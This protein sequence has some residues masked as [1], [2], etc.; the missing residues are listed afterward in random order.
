MAENKMAAMDLIKNNKK[1]HFESTFLLFST[2]NG[3]KSQNN[4]SLADQVTDSNISTKK[5]VIYALICIIS[6]WP[7]SHFEPNEYKAQLNSWPFHYT[8][9]WSW[10]KYRK[11]SPLSP[12]ILDNTF[13]TAKAEWISYFFTKHDG[14]HSYSWIQ[15]VTF[16]CI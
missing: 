13:H 5:T 8:V 12:L 14:H 15:K 4:N 11:A 2:L 3:F 6:R 1:S 10:K 9:K 7:T 16:S